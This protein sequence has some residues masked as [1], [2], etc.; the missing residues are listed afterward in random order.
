MKDKKTANDLNYEEKK[1]IKEDV[2]NAFDEAFDKKVPKTSIYHTSKNGPKNI[3]SQAEVDNYVKKRNRKAKMPIIVTAIIVSLITLAVLY[4][5]FFNNPK[6]IFT[7]AI[8]KTFNTLN[9][10]MVSKD[11]IYSK[12]IALNLATS[13]TKFNLKLMYEADT[14]NDLYKMDIK[15]LLNDQ[16]FIDALV[17]NQNGNVYMYSSDLYNKYLKFDKAYMN[18]SNYDTILNSVRMAL[19]RSLNSEKFNGSKQQ[20]RIDGKVESVYKSSVEL[21]ETNLDRILDSVM[22]DLENDDNLFAAFNQNSKMNKAEF[23]SKIKTQVTEVNKK[24]T[25]KLPINIS[26]YTKGALQKFVMLEIKTLRENEIYNI[27]KLSDTK[28]TYTFED[29]ILKIKKEGTINLKDNGNILVESKN[30]HNKLDIIIK[31]RKID[32]VNKVDV[33]DY[34]KI[35]TLSESEKAKMTVKLFTNPLIAKMVGQKSS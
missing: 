12:D 24:L 13:D 35:D 30:S 25:K 9:D 22:V 4:L 34:V 29:K 17:Y 14:K 33:S 11:D 18:S 7:K 10:F 3:L 16:K 2:K 5:Y 32:K 6:T 15:T 27:T 20:M 28:Y 26:I 19:I 1:E 21:N 23:K 8:D 31:E